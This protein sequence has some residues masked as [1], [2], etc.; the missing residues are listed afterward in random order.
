MGSTGQLTRQGHGNGPCRRCPRW[1]PPSQRCC[2]R[3]GTRKLPPLA[4]SSAAAAPASIYDRTRTR[5]AT[6]PSASARRRTAHRNPPPPR[7]TS[8]CS[9]VPLRHRRRTHPH[10]PRTNPTQRLPPPS[11]T[12]S[13]PHHRPPT[14]R[15]RVCLQLCIAVPAPMPSEGAEPTGSDVA[16][17][18]SAHRDR[19]GITFPL[20]SIGR[21][22]IVRHSVGS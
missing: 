17:S 22:E 19:L 20:V 3:S 5:A 4:A 15:C 6:T 10:H 11:P 12:L 14:Q 16:P 7:S 9:N 18:A 2:H 1:S 13:H 21:I 8:T